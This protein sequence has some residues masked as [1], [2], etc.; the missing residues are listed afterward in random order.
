LGSSG[1]DPPLANLEAEITL[2]DSTDHS[3]PVDG[4]LCGLKIISGSTYNTDIE[5]DTYTTFTFLGLYLIE[6]GCIIF[7]ITLWDKGSDPRQPR[8]KIASTRSV[9]CVW[10]LFYTTKS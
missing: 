5:G 3:K 2:L 1:D 10:T 8:R 9:P 4:F 6:A 7:D